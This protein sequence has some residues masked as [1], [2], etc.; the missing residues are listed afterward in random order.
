MSCSVIGHVTTSRSSTEAQPSFIHGVQE[1]LHMC[2]SSQ[3]SSSRE[4]SLCV[5]GCLAATAWV[6]FEN[7]RLHDWISRGFLMRNFTSSHIW[8]SHENSLAYYTIWWQF[9]SQIE[10]KSWEKLPGTFQTFNNGF[11]FNTKIRSKG[12]LFFILR[13]RFAYVARDFECLSLWDL[14]KRAW[15]A[16]STEHPSA[17]YQS[18]FRCP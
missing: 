14:M 3:M 5:W 7:P 15:F 16:E 9:L 6:A 2:S 11:R 1:K 13:L 12:F 18:P 8:R 4:S 10:I 17:E